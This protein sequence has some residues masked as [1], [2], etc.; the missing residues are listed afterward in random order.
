M[1]V[2]FWFL[3]WVFVFFFAFVLVFC[4]YGFLVFV[5]L[6]FVV[7]MAWKVVCL[8]V[9]SQKSTCWKV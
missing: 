9:F 7:S 6:G 1:F 2:F 8:F 5:F 3:F 4:F